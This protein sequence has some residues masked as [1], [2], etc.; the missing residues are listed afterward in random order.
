[1]TSKLF[2]W[3]GAS[4]DREHAATTLAVR[5]HSRTEPDRYSCEDGGDGGNNVT[6]NGGGKVEAGA[7]AIAAGTEAS[8]VFVAGTSDHL[9]QFHGIACQSSGVELEVS[10]RYIDDA[11]LHRHAAHSVK[12]IVAPGRAAPSI[13]AMAVAAATAVNTAI[14]RSQQQHPQL[15]L[16]HET[17]S[18]SSASALVPPRR[19][20]FAVR[21]RGI[22]QS[23]GGAVQWS[24][25]TMAALQ[26]HIRLGTISL[27]ISTLG[28][29][30]SA[31]GDHSPLHAAEAE[32]LAI[33]Q[34]RVAIALGDPSLAGRCKLFVAWS[35]S[36]RGAYAAAEM[37]IASLERETIHRGSDEKLLHMCAAARIKMTH[38]RDV[39]HP[40]AAAAAQQH[41]HPHPHPHQ[42][43]KITY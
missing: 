19:M 14:T 11:V 8:V 16:L 27:W 22:A 42:H 25:I 39:A 29:A 31:L 18:P 6:D 21:V 24:D 10:V 13:A 30:Y 35:Y 38:L 9:A 37:A 15:R 41:P 17:I 3:Q 7:R 20:V 36:Q 40:K 26:R 28:G 1:M 2:E 4:F 43:R 23:M 5:Q 32:L 33:K 34:Y 12:E